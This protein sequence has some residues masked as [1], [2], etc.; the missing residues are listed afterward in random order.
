MRLLVTGA[1]GFIGRATCARLA[2]GGMDVVA[3]IRRRTTALPAGVSPM[4][5]G[6]LHADTPWDASLRGVTGVIH[7]AAR[8]HVTDDRARDPLD[9]FRRVNVEGTVRVARRAAQAGVTR[10][11][12]VSSVKVH[13]EQRAAPYTEHDVPAPADAYA[14]SKWEA[15]QALREIERET[16]ME[17]AIVRPPLV[18]G[19]G[20]RAN[21]LSLLEAVHKR[22]PLPLGLVRNRRSLIFVGNLADALAQCVTHS[23][24]A[25]RTFLVSDG[26]DVSTASLIRHLADAMHTRA[27]LLPVPVGILRMTARLTGKGDAMTRLVSSLSVDSRDIR[28]RLDWRPPFSLREG[29]AATVADFLDS[30]AH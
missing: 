27:I 4:V 23:N 29:L 28:D 11:V 25:G 6:E 26:E 16:G 30:R 8:V 15:E 22:I 21:F 18:Y 9:E 10:F 13:G 24:G 17:V 12:F 14:Q 20:V 5:V 2:S 19:P 7:L 3:A 1:N